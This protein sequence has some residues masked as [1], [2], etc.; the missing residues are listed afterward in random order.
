MTYIVVFR[1]V[2]DAK[3]IAKIVEIVFPLLNNVP[4]LR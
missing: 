2:L 1:F 3:E 4:D